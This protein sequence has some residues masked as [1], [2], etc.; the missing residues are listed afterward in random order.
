MV[1]GTPHYAAAHFAAVF[2]LAATT[3]E[4]DSAAFMLDS[5]YSLSKQLPAAPAVPPFALNAAFGGE[6]T[7]SA[8]SGGLA[9]G[10]ADSSEV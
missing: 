7:D 1:G 6:M 2:N 8:L 4:S 3:T 9:S 5:G 10:F